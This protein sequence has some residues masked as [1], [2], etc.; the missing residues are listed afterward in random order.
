MNGVNEVL[1]R[2]HFTGL[3]ER[4]PWSLVKTDL[5][6]SHAVWRRL[7]PP[8][9]CSLHALVPLPVGKPTRGADHPPHTPP[10]GGKGRRVEWLFIPLTHLSAGVH[11]CMRLSR[12][13]AAALA[14]LLHC[15]F[16]SVGGTKNNCRQLTYS[17]CHTGTKGDS[18]VNKWD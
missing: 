14:A 5:C 9:S 2:L 13:P 11:L 3:K 16:I 15:D 4:G 10:L 18:G 6:G 7:R 8:R 17:K 12:D 1:A